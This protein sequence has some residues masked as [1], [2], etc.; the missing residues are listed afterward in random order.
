MTSKTFLNI[1]IAIN[2]LII[3]VIMFIATTVYKNITGEFHVMG[4]VF[5][6]ILILLI[7]EFVSQKFNLMTIFRNQ[8]LFYL[9]IAQ[10]IILSLV[11]N[12][13]IL[14]LVSLD[15]T[16]YMVYVITINLYRIKNLLR[17]E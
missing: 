3:G 7:V 15:F 8:F 11:K 6:T 5:V 2:I 17:K 13:Y 14:F 12:N 10:L 16:L 1:F 4:M 9:M